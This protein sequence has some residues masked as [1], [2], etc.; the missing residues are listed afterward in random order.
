MADEP[1]STEHLAMR[2]AIAERDRRIEE[3]EAEAAALAG[4]LRDALDFIASWDDV[5][6]AGVE[7]VERLEPV[8]A[9][10]GLLRKEGES[11]E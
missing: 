11:D 5:P 4:A 10:A 6:N 7:I 1:L 9:A 8:L 3:L 2:E